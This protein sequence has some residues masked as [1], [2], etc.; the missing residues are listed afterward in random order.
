MD[1]RIP[2]SAK[3]ISQKLLQIMAGLVVFSIL[4]RLALAYLPDL[5]LRNLFAD[6]FYLDEENNIPSLY[7]FLLLM[8]AASTLFLISRIEI[9]IRGS[10]AKSWQI[11]SLIFVYLAI[12]EMIALHERLNDILHRFGLGKGMNFIW[13]LPASCVVLVIASTFS[14][15]L[16]HL[17]RLT[18]LRIIFAGG[19]FLL[20]AVG[21][22]VITL[23]VLHLDSQVG[24][25]LYQIFMTSEESCEML[26]V[27][28]FINAMLIHLNQHYGLSALTL[29]VPIKV[30]LPP[31]ELDDQ[32]IYLSLHQ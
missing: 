12:D 2:L 22:E 15:F 20:G 3:G 27:I 31:T 4:G 26:G 13:I 28:A 24:D 18:R 30:N 23:G 9:T 11:L 16:F 7:S 8:L 14:K 1:M 19:L 29:Q 10:Y 25:L 32:D 17:P 21:I 5:P 6:K